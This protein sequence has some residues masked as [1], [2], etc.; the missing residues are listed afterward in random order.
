MS[1]HGY[2]LERSRHGF[3]VAARNPTVGRKEVATWKMLSRYGLVSKGSRPHFGVTTR[4]AAGQ[5]KTLWQ[6]GPG[7]ATMPGE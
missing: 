2:Q 1:Q 7:V 4:P 3:G 6:F 5:G